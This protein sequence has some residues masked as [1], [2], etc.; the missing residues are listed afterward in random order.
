VQGFINKDDL[1]VFKVF[2]V[3]LNMGAEGSAG[4]K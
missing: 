2:C 4:L 1:T 3:H